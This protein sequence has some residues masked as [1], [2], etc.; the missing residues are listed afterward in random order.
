MLAALTTGAWADTNVTTATSTALDTATAGN[1]TIQNT[2]GVGV[3]TSAGAA[4]TINSDS[5]VLNQGYISN[6]NTEQAIGLW[7]NTAGGNIVSPSIGFANTG[8]VEVAGSGTAKAAIL[9]SGGNSFYGPISL[10]TLTSTATVGSASASAVTAASNVIVKGDYSSAL[11]LTQG[12]TMVGNI[13][14]NGGISQEASDKSTVA[15]G[16][17]VNLDGPLYGNFVNQSRIQGIGPGMRGVQLT[18]GLLPCSS[19]TPADGFTCASI[20]GGSFVNQGAISLNGVYY[21]NTRGGNAQ[22]G[23]AVAIG[24]GIAGGFLN[25]GPATSSN[26]AAAEISSN[27]LVTAPVVWI[28]PALSTNASTLEPRGPVLIGPVTADIDAVNPGYS[29]INRGA[30]SGRPVDPQF[31]SVAVLIQGASA[32]NYTCL[33]SRAASCDLAPNSVTQTVNGNNVQVNN[34]GGLLNTGSIATESTTNVP[35][36]STQTGGRITATAINIGAYAT[37]PRIDVTAQNISGSSTT[38]AIVSALVSGVGQGNAFGILIDPNANVPAINISANAS[39]IASVTT[40]TPSPDAGIATAANPFSLISEAIVDNSSTLR[41]INNAGKIEATNTDLFPGV[42]AVVVNVERAIDMQNSSLSGQ[43]VTINNSGHILGDVLL[44]AVSSGSV[45]T[46]GNVNGVANAGTG[47]VNT[48][49]NYAVLARQIVS[50]ANGVPP[51]TK[52][53]LLDFGADANPTLTV[54]G[55][56]YV[57]ADIRANPGALNVTVQNNGILY[58]ANSGSSLQANVFNVQTNGTLGLSI[59][60]ANASSGTP[61]IEANSAN[62]S[63]GNLALDFGSFISSGFT[64]A[65]TAN[66]TVQTITLIRTPLGQ[67]TD[68]SLAQQNATL[69][70]NIPFLFESPTEAGYSGGT[71]LA[72]GTSGGQQVLTLSLIPRS[73][74][75]TN[76]DGTAGLN[77]K[78]EALQVFPNAVAALGNDAGLGSAIARSLTVYNQPGLASSGINIDA[79]QQQAQIAFSQFAP[80]VS[81][82]ARD[83]AVMITDQASGPVAARQ[84]L[85]RSFAKVPGEMTL[86]GEEFSGHINNKGTIAGSGSTVQYKDRG[87]GFSLGVDAG[88]PRNGWYGAAFTFYTGDVSQVQ[89]RLT[90]TET[91]W[92][93]LTGYSHWQG[94]KVFVDSQLAVAYGDFTGNRGI[95]IGGVFRN[96]TSKRASQMVALGGKMGVMLKSFGIDMD[97]YASLDGLTMREEGYTEANGGPGFNLQVA[98][99]YASSLRTALGAD[100]KT[101]V[102]LW[103]IELSPE[104]RVGYRYDLMHQAVKVKAAFAST[105]GTGTVG[106]T[107]TFVGPDP[108]SGNAILGLG[109]GASTDTWQLGVRYDW[110]RGN[111]GSTTQV[112]TFTVLGRI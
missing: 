43:G 44:P 80:D 87:W 64:A 96:A 2:G 11:Y 79:S 102:N 47:V 22:A 6:G 63:G 38:P 108:D 95:N 74:G 21:A 107:M 48:S 93:M 78:G 110:I 55:F 46:V 56:G 111:N 50:L 103:G 42:G 106:N 75:A 73:T 33:S 37:V 34:T 89:P 112:G 59:S 72:V 29:F 14:V 66:P 88:S 54:G 23:T 30:I 4:V 100:F 84:R 45:I 92:F 35:T 31:S 28:N 1:I 10:T 18:G 19:A 69:S 99:Y 51:V 77:L 25:D 94:R 61:V 41:L 39:V 13:L 27:G 3:K 81:G 7:I 83:I 12:T 68:T 24:N 5:T 8:T 104:A 57:N 16:I 40:T 86:W 90:K 26:K 36:V 9:I 71:P 76:R 65:S 53:A 49:A 85:L 98:P 60:Q 101:G 82:G 109:L 67:I 105:G 62:I 58:V 17:I 70:Q 91:E 32:T 15:S 20:S 52:A 97:P